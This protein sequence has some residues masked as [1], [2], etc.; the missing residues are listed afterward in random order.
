MAGLIDNVDVNVWGPDNMMVTLGQNIPSGEDFLPIMTY[1]NYVNTTAPG[2]GNKF[3]INGAS[4]SAPNS[5]DLYDALSHCKNTYSFTPAIS[6]AWNPNFYGYF[7]IG[8]KEYYT[9]LRIP[10]FTNQGIY[11]GNI[12]IIFLAENVIGAQIYNGYQWDGPNNKVKVV[13][14]LTDDDIE[15][16]IDNQ[17]AYIVV[18]GYDE[19]IE[20]VSQPISYSDCEGGYNCFDDYCDQHCGEPETC[21]DCQS[22][23]NKKLYLEQIRIDPDVRYS[24]GGTIYVI[25]NHFVDNTGGKYKLALYSMVAHGNNK[26]TAIEGQ[27]IRPK[28]TQHEVVR[29]KIR[30]NGSVRGNGGTTTWKTVWSKGNA[31]EESDGKGILL[32]GNFNPAKAKVYISI[33]EKDAPFGLSRDISPPLSIPLNPFWK[34]QGMPTLTGPG[35]SS[36]FSDESS[37]PTIWPTSDCFYEVL[38]SMW[39][40]PVG[41]PLNEIIVTSTNVTFKLKFY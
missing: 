16:Y 11:N 24:K 1:H 18:V 41:N 23:T 30:N 35:K 20:G 37:N 32:S 13:L 14:N 34:S 36:F 33:S 31:Q 28:W 39:L 10:E 25:D 19:M 26:Y 8:A 9:L 2:F 17:T 22:Q 29:E 7:S 38:P 12:P 27:D 5:S 40:D 6:P 21:L 15:P 3:A 4:K